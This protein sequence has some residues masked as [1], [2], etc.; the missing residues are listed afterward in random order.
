MTEQS[1]T[2]TFNHGYPALETLDNDAR[3]TRRMGRIGVLTE[4]LLS[5]ICHM[6]GEEASDGL[7]ARL[8]Q[9]GGEIGKSTRTI[10]D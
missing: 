1:N 7:K 9:A 2:L 3:K 6:A 5:E 4:M 10:L 8:I